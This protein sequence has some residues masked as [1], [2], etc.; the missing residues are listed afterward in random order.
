LR[1]TP[2]GS[3]FVF[4]DGSARMLNASMHKQTMWALCTRNNGEVIS[5]DSY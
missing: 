2:F 3:H 5:A 4:M 1:L